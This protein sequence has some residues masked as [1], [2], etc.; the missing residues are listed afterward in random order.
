MDIQ[1]VT[2]TMPFLARNDLYKIEKPYGADFPVDGIKGAS[3]TNHIF[4]T[5]PINFHDARQL[6]VPLTLDDNGCCLIKAK[7]SLVAEDAT[8]ERSE[9]MSR[10]TKE[11]MNIVKQNFPQYVEV[12]FADFQVRKRSAAFPDGHGQ[13]VEFAQPAAVPHTDFSVAGALRRMAEILPGEEDQYIHR[14]FDL[15][16]VWKVLKGPNN[17]WPLAVCDYK[18]VDLSAD[19]TAN[20]ALHLTGVGENWLLHHNNKQRWYY[21]SSMD[22]DDLIVFRN[23]DSKGKLSLRY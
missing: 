20:D 18:T 21:F 3:I 19:T 13:R 10:F 22:I 5:V 16:N 1:T 4:D 11:V 12:K 8:N 6:S 17:D 9:S 2:S 14:E 15:I 7:T 23:S